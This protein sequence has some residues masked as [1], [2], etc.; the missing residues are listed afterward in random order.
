MA[1]TSKHTGAQIDLA[2]GSGS[3][4]T[5]VIKDF[6]TLSGSSTSTI[7]IGAG[8]IAQHITASGNISASGNLTVTGNTTIAGNTTMNGDI[9][10][11]NGIAD[12]I[13][14]KGD[15]SSSFRPNSRDKFDIG[16]SSFAFNRVYVNAVH[17]TGSTPSLHANETERLSIGATNIFTGNLSASGA[18]NTLSHITASGNVKVAGNIL[19]NGN[20]VGDDSTNI[21]NIQRI[22]LDG[23]QISGS[24][25]NTTK[26]SHG[27][28]YITIAAKEITLDSFTQG[29]PS[30]A[31]KI[32]FKSDNVSR[33]YFTLSGSTQ[34]EFYAVYGLE[35][36]SGGKIKLESKNQPNV[37]VVSHSAVGIGT[38]TPGE[39]LEVKGNISSS[40]FISAS[41]VGFAD[42]PTEAGKAATGGLFTL[43]GS[44]LPFATGSNGSTVRALFNEFSSSKFVLIK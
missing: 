24:S 35:I 19:A 34:Q 18:F 5:G 32:H 2:I 17:I 44:Q 16:S 36:G 43:S 40:G 33:A 30:Q 6:N 29:T 38:A 37:L 31:G 9:T 7:K 12:N 27:T 20:I 15:I 21:T 4:T 14:I 39:K 41:R 1:Y 28:G 42:L 13:V 22:E 26:L 10:L 8:L 11:G 23:L 25:G 3:T